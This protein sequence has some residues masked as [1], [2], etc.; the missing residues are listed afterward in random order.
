MKSSKAQNLFKLL[1]RCKKIRQ[2]DRNNDTKNN[3]VKK[4]GREKTDQEK[5]DRGTLKITAIL[6]FLMLAKSLEAI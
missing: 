5:I 1:T 4:V 2:Q 3:A 6:E